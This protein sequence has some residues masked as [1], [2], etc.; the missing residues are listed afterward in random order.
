MPGRKCVKCGARLPDPLELC[1]ECMCKAGAGAAEVEA[2]E[3]LRD[4]ADVLSITA[5]TDGNIKRAMNGILN[6][7]ERLER[8]KDRGRRE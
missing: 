2:A 1:P 4:I 6:I 3:E 7:A 5:D 8:K